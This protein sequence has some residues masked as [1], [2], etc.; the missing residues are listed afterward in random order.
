MTFQQKYKIKEL[1]KECME[2][3]I[4]EVK[5]IVE[6]VDERYGTVKLAWI[7]TIEKLKTNDK[8]LMICIW[9]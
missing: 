1:I 2:S 5:E 9:A 8:S 3:N 7:F 4:M 6:K